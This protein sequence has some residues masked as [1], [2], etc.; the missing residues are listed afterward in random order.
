[1]SYL[2]LSLA[3]LGFGFL[4]VVVKIGEQKGSSPLGLTTCL[5]ISAGILTSVVL[6]INP[7]SH[8]GFS[9]QVMC[10][11]VVGG[12]GGALAFTLFLSALSVGHFGLSCTLISLGFVIPV[13]FSV[14]FWH[15]SL[16][17]IKSAGLALIISS[18]FMLT[19]SASSGKER[20]P[21]WLKWILCMAGAICLNGILYI[22]QSFA[23]KYNYDAVQFLFVVYISGT[24]LLLFFSIPKRALDRKTFMFGLLCGAGSFLGCF[25]P[26][27]AIKEGLSPAVV[28]P[29]VL[30]GPVITGVLSSLFIFKEKIDVRGYAGIISGFIGIILLSGKW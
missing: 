8:G 22:T 18:V 16:G 27:P 10:L 19:Y 14:L 20:K 12:V 4:N 24:V 3:V 30:G 6:L 17:I 2:Y 7:G 9:W 25:F 5:F 15:D 21:K 11:G 29:V 28:F 13:V 1:M 26:L 23:G